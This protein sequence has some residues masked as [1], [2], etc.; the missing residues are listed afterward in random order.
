M[1]PHERLVDPA[2][3]AVFVFDLEPLLL[4]F[5]QLKT[6]PLF[7]LEQNPEV[8]SWPSPNIDDGTFDNDCGDLFQQRSVNPP[9]VT[10]KV[11]DSVPA[12]RLL[13]DV[14]GIILSRSPQDF[15]ISPRT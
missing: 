4:S 2:H 5:Q 11:T 7:G 1:S 15:V 14:N 10:F 3:L 13:Y 8:C 12:A 9:R 6:D